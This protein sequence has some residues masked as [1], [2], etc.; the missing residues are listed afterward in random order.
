MRFLPSPGDPAGARPVAIAEAPFGQGHVL[1]V[2][3]SLDDAWSPEALV[4]LY[5]V[6]LNDAALLLTAPSSKGRNVLVGQP[7]Q[8]PVPRDA[9]AL[10]VKGPSRGEEAPGLRAAPD[11]SSKPTAV[12]ERVGASGIW[13]LSYDRV[14]RGA[15]TARAEELFAANV[16]P[17]ESSLAR[18]PYDLVRSKAPVIRVLPS[19]EEAVA[20]RVEARQGEVTSWVLF[21][22]GVLLLLEPWLAMRFGRHGHTTARAPRRD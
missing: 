20:Q 14:V 10:R 4:L 3:T 8:G 12:F 15:E 16:D 13:R 19:Y 21:V 22:V 2:A 9:T 1:A 7:L 5:P 17:L 11:E 6:L 18:A